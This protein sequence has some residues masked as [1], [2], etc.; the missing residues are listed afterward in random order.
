[1]RLKGVGIGFDCTAVK[2]GGCVEVIL[3]VGD[4][5]GVEEGAGVGGVG[6][7]IRVEFGSGRLPVGF[8]DGGFGVGELGGDLRSLR[9]RR[10]GIGRG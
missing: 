1:M 5:A 10:R 3:M 8:D 6:S 7:E 2:A 4:V 9:L